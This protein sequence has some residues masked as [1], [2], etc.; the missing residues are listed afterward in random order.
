MQPWWIWVEDPE[1][2]HIY[3]S[4]YFLL[5]KAKR[6]QTQQLVFSIPIFEPL[7]SQYYIRAVSDRWIGVETLV[8]D[9]IFS[10]CFWL[11]NTIT[12]HTHTHTHTQ[13]PL[14]FKHLMLPHEYP[15]H[16]RLLDLQ[17]LP[18]SALH[19][20]SFERL[21][22]FSHFNPIQTQVGWFVCLIGFLFLFPFFFFFFWIYV[23]TGLFPTRYFTQRTTLITICF[24][25]HPPVAERPSLVN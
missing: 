4:E 13:I 6:K 23:M 15:P 8:I 5:H 21:Y 20:E 17:P 25:E 19:N 22:K 7:P 12:T 3:H 10:I 1:N 11:S 18:V 24:W 16:T 9:W 14:S 2:E